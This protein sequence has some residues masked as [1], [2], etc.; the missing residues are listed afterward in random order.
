MSEE[1]KNNE[2]T[3]EN[4]AYRKTYWHT[5]SHVMAQAVK[6][7]WPEV[8]L[9]I[10]P[11][12]DNGFYYDFDVDDALHA[13]DPGSRSRRRCGRSCKEKLKLERFEL[14]R[15]EAMEF[16]EEKDEPYKVELINDLP[17]DARHLLLHVR[18][19]SPTCAPAP[20]WT[21]PA[22]SRAVKLMSV[23]GAYWRGSEKNK[24][25]QRIYGTAFA[26]KDELEAY[27]HR[28]EEAKKRDHRKLGQELDLFA[29]MRRGPRL[30]LL[31]AQGHDPQEHADRLLARGPHASTA[32]WRSPP[33]SSS[34]ARCGSAPAT[35]ITTS[36]TCTPPSSTTRTYAIKPM[37]CP[38]GM[39]VYE[40]E[41][42]SYRDLPLRDG[43][44]GPGAPA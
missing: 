18:A 34:T 7:L 5:C 41:P 37:N 24:M 12:I 42:H 3:F 20:I 31:P 40:S 17:E 21:P 2:Y 16:M 23:A 1:V 44:A 29:I 43:R 36:R 28:I 13:G 35:G 10:G 4:P 30:P 19:T 9:A 8:K 26:K 11:A 27:L 15:E 38:G 22:R 39:L 25:L 14:P 33:P 32:M 6:R